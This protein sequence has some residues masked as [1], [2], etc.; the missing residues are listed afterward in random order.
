MKV[1]PREIE[2]LRAMTPALWSNLRD[3]LTEAE[4]LLA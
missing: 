2:L 3:E 1:T 4:N